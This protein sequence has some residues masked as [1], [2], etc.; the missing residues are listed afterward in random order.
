MR[1]MFVSFRCG[2]LP[3]FIPIESG[4]NKPPYINIPTPSNST[5]LVDDRGVNGAT[6]DITDHAEQND[7]I[8]L[9]QEDNE[10]SLIL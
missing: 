2:L 6:E 7:K 5:I 8:E 9:E 10:K 1:R 4:Q 3:S